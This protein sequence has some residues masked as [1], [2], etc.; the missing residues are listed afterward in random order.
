MLLSK[1]ARIE[2]C[3]ITRKG[4]RGQRDG[5]VATVGG[6]VDACRWTSR[7]PQVAKYNRK[8]VPVIGGVVGNRK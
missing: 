6:K 5:A 3:A 2:R 7:R 8:I 1:I 4:F